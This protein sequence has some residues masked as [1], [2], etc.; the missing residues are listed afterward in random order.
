MNLLREINT[1][2]LL[3]GAGPLLL[4]RNMSQAAQKAAV[5]IS[6]RVSVPDVSETYGINTCHINGSTPGEKAAKQC[7]STWY[8]TVKDLDWPS[9]RV[10]TKSAQFARLVWKA[11]THVGIGVSGSNVVVYFD[12]PS[13][14][15][16]SAKDNISPVTGTCF[17]HTV[18]RNKSFYVAIT[19]QLLKNF[20]ELHEF[21][22]DVIA[23][24]L[25]DVNITFLFS[26]CY[27]I[28]HGLHGLVILF[29]LIVC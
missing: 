14:E 27:V 5:T 22:C 10:T 9:P 12:P 28:Q 16:E 11:T 20:L 17:S 29:P 24:M 6:K 8:K 7:I 21:A 19:K 13:N 15:V 26:F 25:D 3:H 4:E 2:R 18:D 1:M 23:A